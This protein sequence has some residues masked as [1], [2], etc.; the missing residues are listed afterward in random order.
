MGSEKGGKRSGRDWIVAYSRT[1][2]DVSAG[3]PWARP[4][5]KKLANPKICQLKQ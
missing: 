5:M 3:A 1:G 4:D 2:E